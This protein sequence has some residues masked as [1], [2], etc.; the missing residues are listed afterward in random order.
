L[1]NI[2]QHLRTD[3]L[4]VRCRLAGETARDPGQGRPI[5]YKQRPAPDGAPPGTRRA[6]MWHFL[7]A[8]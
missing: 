6:R 1:L 7:S 2:K 4:A 8:I 3:S 5:C